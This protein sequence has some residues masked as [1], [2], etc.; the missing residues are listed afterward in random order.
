MKSDLCWRC[1]SDWTHHSPHWQAVRPRLQHF[2]QDSRCCCPSRASW[3]PSG[4][5]TRP[6]D[7]ARAITKAPISTSADR[8]CMWD[9]QA[10]LNQLCF[11]LAQIQHTYKAA[12]MSHKCCSRISLSYT[13]TLVETDRAV[14]ELQHTTGAAPSSHLLLCGFKYP[15]QRPEALNLGATG[16]IWHNDIR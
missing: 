8:G 9:L 10:F 3:E 15:P 6:S 5:T 11:S 13:F 14:T 2:W 12:A 4:Q 7:K 1:V 16:T